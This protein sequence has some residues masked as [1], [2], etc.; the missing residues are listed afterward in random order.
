MIAVR[1]T[2]LILPLLGL[3]ITGLC[4]AGPEQTRETKS[5]LLF[6]LALLSQMP[7]RQA[8]DTYAI[9]AFEEDIGHLKATA[10]ESQKLQTLQIFLVTVKTP[11]D[12]KRCNLL[13]IQ[14]YSTQKPLELQQIIQKESVLTVV[15]SGNKFSEYGHVEI[16]EQDKHYQFALHLTSAKQAGIVFDTRLMKLATNIIN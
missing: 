13:Y 7:N 9:C 3:S 8:Q 12:V 1:R 4:Q 11:A 10:I 16:S 14:D 15:Y 2:C 6:N 5:E